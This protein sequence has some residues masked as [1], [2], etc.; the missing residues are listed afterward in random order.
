MHS[1]GLGSGSKKK[2]FY[3]NFCV[4]R[5]EKNDIRPQCAPERPLLPRGTPGAGTPRAAQ[6]G[7]GAPPHAD[8]VAGAASVSSEY[9]AQDVERLHGAHCVEVVAVVGQHGV[10]KLHAPPPVEA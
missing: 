8:S 7:G 5:C 1:F 2:H 9:F 10:E 6:T 3:R 4:F